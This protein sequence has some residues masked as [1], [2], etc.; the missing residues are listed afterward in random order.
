MFGRIV[1]TLRDI[2]NISADYDV[3]ADY[4]ISADCD[5]SAND[6]K[7]KKRLSRRSQAQTRTLSPT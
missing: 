5:I 2:Y 1:N 7:K 4:N 6:D 3:G